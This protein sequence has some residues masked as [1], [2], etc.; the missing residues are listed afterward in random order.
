M[1]YECDQCEYVT[2]QKSNYK[3][4]TNVHDD[5]RKYNCELC[6]A[7][8]KNEN[9]LRTHIESKHASSAGGVRVFR[10]PS[11]DCEEILLGT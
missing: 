3:K 2:D 6:K 7:A 11:L 4:H 8:Y 1:S 9:S 10:C 5:V